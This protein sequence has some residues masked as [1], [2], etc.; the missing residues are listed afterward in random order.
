M[1]DTRCIGIRTSL[2]A[3]VESIG[4]PKGGGANGQMPNAREKFAHKNFE[5]KVVCPWLRTELCTSK[6]LVLEKSKGF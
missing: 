4:V 1:L 5:S 2:E 3:T 6:V